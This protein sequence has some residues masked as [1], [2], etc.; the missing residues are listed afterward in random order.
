MRDD[1]RV[2]PLERRPTKLPAELAVYVRGLCTA[3]EDMPD[4]FGRYG[5][6]RAEVEALKPKADALAA[7]FR[8]H[9]DEV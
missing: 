8:E 9:L 4:Q 6:T 2:V 7:A 3:I 5:L 1:D